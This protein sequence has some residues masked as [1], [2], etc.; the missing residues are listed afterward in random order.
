MTTNH[1][2]FTPKCIKTVWRLGFVR[3]RWL[4]EMTGLQDGQVCLTVG[5]ESLTRLSF[6]WIDNRYALVLSLFE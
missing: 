3:T 4:R 2:I 6:G 5:N 1:D